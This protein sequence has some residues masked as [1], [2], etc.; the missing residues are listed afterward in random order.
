MTTDAKFIT[1]LRELKALTI[2]KCVKLP[3]R[4]NATVADPLL[5]SVGKAKHLAMKANSYWNPRTKEEL[6]TRESLFQE[7]CS[8]LEAFAG[9]V[10]DLAEIGD[11][12]HISIDDLNE[13]TEKVYSSLSLIR[14]VMESDGK[15]FR[16]LPSF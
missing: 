2:R 14:R 11:L 1:E 10:D 5:K 3:K 16:G 15:R 7:A 13:W 4:Y 12:F 8:E 9:D 6:Q